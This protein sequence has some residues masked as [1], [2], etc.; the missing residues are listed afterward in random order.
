MTNTCAVPIRVYSV[1]F[2]YPGSP[3]AILMKD[4]QSD[5]FLTKNQ[6]EWVTGDPPVPAA[7]V[8]GT[9]PTIQ[10]VFT[11]NEGGS[12]GSL[13]IGARAVKGE[14]GIT[15]QTVDITFNQT[16]LTNPFE[17]KF[18]AALPK[19]IGKHE[20][21]WEWYIVDGSEKVPITTTDH[22]IYTTYRPI[23]AVDSAQQD[24]WAYLPIVEWTSEWV[25]GSLHDKDVCDAII[26]NAYRSGLKYVW[27]TWM[28]SPL[29]APSWRRILRWLV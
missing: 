21:S 20:I 11:Q 14:I 5:Q 24:N 16:A 15:E 28:E 29:Y 10:V 3:T 12:G 6:P 4:P 22:I 13:T 27:S 7:Y 17:F 26:K 8:Q 18:E 9:Q 2:A 25:T 23:I 1:N 19:E